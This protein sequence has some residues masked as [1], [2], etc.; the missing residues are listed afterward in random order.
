MALGFP[1][2][3]FFMAAGPANKNSLDSQGATRVSTA[4]EIESKI[5][6]KGE[7]AAFLEK[8]CLVIGGQWFTC[9]G[10]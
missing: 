8:R 6:E 10:V 4:E 5:P 3:F 1:H 7:W 9:T 2:T